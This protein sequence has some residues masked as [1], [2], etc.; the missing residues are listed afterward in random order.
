MDR[1]SI[2]IRF[3][4]QKE[5]CIMTKLE[6]LLEAISQKVVFIQT[7]N[8][9]DQ[10]ALATA[11]GLKILLEHYGK[12]AIVFYKGE[13]DKYN[14][15]KMI[16]LLKLDILPAD[17]IE[18]RDDDEIILVDCQYGNI[19][20]KGYSGKVIACIDHHQLKSANEYRFSDIRP[21]LGACS[22]IIAEYFFEN[23]IP[24]DKLV[25]T[26]LA[27]GIR[28]DTNM[29]S[30]CV[31]DL[32]LDFYCK[33]YKDS[34]KSILHQLDSCTLRIQDLVTYH[35]AIANVKIYHNIALVKLDPNSSE[36]IM[37]QIADFFITLREVDLVFTHCYR[38]GGVKFNSRSSIE[39]IDAC[40]VIRKALDTFGDGGGHNT[41]A[42]GFV[43]D[44]PNLNAATTIC[45]IAEERVIDY[46]TELMPFPKEKKGKFRRIKH[47]VSVWSTSEE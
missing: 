41:M 25:A 22:T 19:N 9:P 35:N 23:N 15:I 18:F 10:D 8:Y 1:M 42:A 26:T 32:D 39:K 46:M 33:L 14:T 45:N 40:E 38:D 12:Q 47:L 29:L 31:S 34:V 37:A 44:V 24:M 21:D 30:R 28:M 5:F 16:E 17:S 27:Y 3:I 11:H 20:V 6:Q 43:K 2:T 7:H 13:I 4:I 36:S